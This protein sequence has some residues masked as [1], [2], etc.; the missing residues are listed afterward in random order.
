MPDGTLFVASGSLNG[1][2]PNNISNNNPTYEILN[3]QGITSGTNITMGILDKNQPYYMYPFIHLLNNGQLFVAVS[4]SAESSTLPQTPLP[5]LCRTCQGTTVHTPT[6]A[7]VCCF[8][9]QAPTAMLQISLFAAAALIRTS[10]ALPNP[11]AEESNP[12]LQIRLGK[13]S[14]CLKAAVW[15]KGLF[16]QTAPSS[17]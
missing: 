2:P 6:L 3:A 10:P 4:K 15:L 7:V 17:G 14:R 12:L 11:A 1:L 16:F 8:P 9:C 13:W 5:R